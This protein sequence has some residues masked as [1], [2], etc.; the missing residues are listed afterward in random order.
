[1]HVRDRLLPSLKAF[2]DLL[3]PRT[4]CVCGRRLATNEDTICTTCFLE[5]PLTGFF[6]NPYENDMAKA[7]WGRITNMEKAVA[8]LYHQAHGDSAHPVYQ[9]KYRGKP[10]LG[11]DLGIVMGRMMMEKGLFDD[12]DAIVPVPLAKKRERQ[13][14]YNQSLM[15]A[16]GLH[17]ISRLPIIDEAV[18]RVAFEGSQTRK[19][20]W[21][22]AENVEHAFELADGNRLRGRHVLV[23]DDVVTTGATVCAVAKEM[24]K[25]G[26]VRVSVAAVGY[27]GQWHAD[28]GKEE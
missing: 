25:A 7:F 14:G 21:D 23:V 4:C 13:R 20:R 2:A 18:R 10:D 17:D 12:I 15:I 6:D 24:E 5:L 27:A 3:A 28:N 22:R 26:E 9:L 1:M 16:L 8:L 11:I 19:D